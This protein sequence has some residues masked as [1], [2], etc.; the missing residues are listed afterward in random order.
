MMP[1]TKPTLQ[2]VHINSDLHRQL[3]ILAAGEGRPIRGLTEELIISGLE[4]RRRK[5]ARSQ[6]GK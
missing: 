4:I 3:K 5:P 6:R 2:T 1:M